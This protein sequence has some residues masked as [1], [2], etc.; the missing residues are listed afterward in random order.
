MTRQQLEDGWRR[1]FPLSAALARSVYPG[2]SPEPIPASA[3]GWEWYTTASGRGIGGSKGT[4]Y[5][6]TDP[7]VP[8]GEYF[9]RPY[10]SGYGVINIPRNPAITPG[11]AARIGDHMV[12]A[13]GVGGKALGMTADQIARGVDGHVLGDRLVGMAGP[14]SRALENKMQTY[15]INYPLDWKERA[16]GVA[17][18]VLNPTMRTAGRVYNG[19]KRVLAKMIPQFMRKSSAANGRTS[20]AKPAVPT[21]ASV[22]A[23]RQ[24]RIP[25]PDDELVARVHGAIADVT[26]FIKE[27]EKFMPNAYRNV[28]GRGKDGKPIYDKWTIGYGQTDI[29]G[30]P[31]R[32]GD[33]ISEADAAKFV[34][35]RLRRNAAEIVRRHDWARNLSRGGLA[36][37]FDLTYNGGTGI[38][39]KTRSPSLN[40]EMDGADMDFD[41]VLRDALPTYR[42][43]NG[44]ELKGLL[45]RRQDAIRR[46]LPT[47]RSS[48]P[49]GS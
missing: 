4:F 29:G 15:D 35:D 48:I 9:V 38:V 32:E 46:W 5:R 3:R 37:L 47:R 11:G 44:V 31:V 6:N 40:Y 8:L 24:Q 34:T 21:R 1:A 45:K 43:A 27:Y 30:R 2:H 13:H 25:T 28:I 42:F 14:L 26:P 7:N 17:A 39:S 10:P 22:K 20:S 12:R 49:H 36:A 33:T 19:T 23:N 41:A 16:S 18:D